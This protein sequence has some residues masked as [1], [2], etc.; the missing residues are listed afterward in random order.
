VV[1]SELANEGIR[2]DTM[3]DDSYSMKPLVTKICGLLAA[4][5]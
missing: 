5:R 2:V 4:Q 3:P 1:A